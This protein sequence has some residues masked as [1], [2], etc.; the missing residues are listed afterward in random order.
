MDSS[1]S[2]KD[3]IGF[4]RVYHHISNAVYP[5]N[6]RLDGRQAG[7]EGFGE[8]DSFQPL[9]DTEPQFAHISCRKAELFI[10]NLYIIVHSLDKILYGEKKIN[11]YVVI[12]WHK[13]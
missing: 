11:R 5:S 1:V 9:L 8:H 4:L 13:S 2:P 7:V 6:R 3:E 10:F 12:G